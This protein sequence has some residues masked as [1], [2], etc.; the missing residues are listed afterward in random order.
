M[1]PTI[2]PGISSNTECIT[3]AE[4]LASSART[5]ELMR[6]LAAHKEHV[7]AEYVS[8]DALDGVTEAINRLADRLTASSCT[9]CSRH[10]IEGALEIL[11][12]LA[13][14]VLFA[15]ALVSRRN[16]GRKS[17]FNFWRSIELG[18]RH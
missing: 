3:A 11:M 8:R 7:A 15:M 17:G 1:A 9:S 14:L 10:M 5:V 18:R 6:E 4:T 13:M 12:P 2:S 16:R